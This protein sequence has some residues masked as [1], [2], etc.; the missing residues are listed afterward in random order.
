MGEHIH[1]IFFIQLTT[2]L[3]K[4]STEGDA[5]DS[6]AWLPFPQCFRVQIYN[7]FFK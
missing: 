2:L 4:K 1:P 7:L 3:N 5:L 6:N